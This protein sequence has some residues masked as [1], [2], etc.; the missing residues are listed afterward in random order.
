MFWDLQEDTSELVATEAVDDED[1]GGVD[2]EKD[3]RKEA[4][5]NAPDGESTQQSVSTRRHVFS[6]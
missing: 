1:G 3:I 4:Q 6:H 2:H 5:E